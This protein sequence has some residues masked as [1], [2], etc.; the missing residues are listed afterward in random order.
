MYTNKYIIEYQQFIITI[1]YIQFEQNKNM[2]TD[3]AH[4]NV[5]IEITI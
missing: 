2:N 1:L 5:F 4:Q 3:T